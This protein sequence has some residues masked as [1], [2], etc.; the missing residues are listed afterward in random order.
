MKH[1]QQNKNPITIVKFTKSEAVLSFL[2]VKIFFLTNL[3]FAQ[4]EY[5]CKL[6]PDSLRENAH[7]VVRYMREEFYVKSPAKATQ[8][9]RKV[10]TVLDAGGD[11]YA[12]EEI[13]YDDQRRI[14]DIK[15]TLYDA[16]GHEVAKL[17]KKNIRDISLY[18]EAFVHDSRL[19]IAYLRG[20]DYPYTVEYEYETE[21]EGSLFY[22]DWHPQFDEFLAVQKSEFHVSVPADIPLRYKQYNIAEP[23]VESSEKNRMSYRW[24]LADRAATEYESFSPDNIL[25]VVYTA[26]SLF[27]F[28]GYK[29][30]LKTWDDFARW[31]LHLN[32]D[33]DELPED[34]R[35]K[36]KTMT[37][38]VASVEE[39]VKILYEFM[40]K[41]TRYV[42]V[43]L[44]V[45]GWQPIA[46]KD[47]YKHGYG[48]CKALSNYMRALLK[49]AGITAHYTLVN[50]GRRARRLLADLPGSS[51]NHAILCVPLQKD[52]MWLECTSQSDPTGFLGTFTDDRDVLVISDD[53]GKIAHTTVYRTEDNAE[54]RRIEA[55][56]E[57]DGSVT[58]N[59]SATYRCT[60]AEHL[61]SLIHQTDPVQQRKILE[62]MLSMP[63]ATL[64]SYEFSEEKSRLPVVRE[65]LYVKVKD[66]ISEGKKEVFLTPDL[67][68]R[69]T[70]LPIAR[71]R[72]FDI[73]I[74][75]GYVE[76]DTIV[77]ELPKLYKLKMPFKDVSLQ[78]RFGEYGL[79]VRE[80]G[81]KLIYTR[82]LK[83]HP[84]NHSK[85]F[86][87]E[88]ASF[89]KDIAGYD[90]SK[91]IFQKPDTP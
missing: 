85:E 33:R 25:P 89:A 49:E 20:F 52:T 14:K 80:E 77:Y 28:Y 3:V 82:Y 79:K 7:A 48:D 69:K 35:T 56:L 62:E 42:N 81:G 54:R 67:F 44:G 43:S 4:S 22:P 12:E 53:Q 60:K 84:G 16:F 13:Y 19:K 63:G 47:V 40:Q 74:R 91:V 23:V 18:G 32:K 51:F 76:E 1:L 10:I 34:L 55:K 41:S 31:V 26:P 88:L 59:V 70:G 45:G 15:G 61:Q 75:R 72:K 46:A 86:Y 68:I 17:S 37:D 71:D 64:E 2:I 57:G 36:V 73:E 87:G 21:C 27:E 39:K 6:I 78:N 83:I 65:R 30:E 90:R 50:A 38:G 5:D 8:K 11:G 24:Q 29:G 58:A 66:K 9:V